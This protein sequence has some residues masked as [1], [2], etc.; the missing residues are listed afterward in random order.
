VSKIDVKW[1][2]ICWSKKDPAVLTRIGVPAATRNIS[3]RQLS[4]GKIAM[5]DERTSNYTSRCVFTTGSAK[6]GFSGATPQ[7]NPLDQS[8]SWSEG[9][10]YGHTFV[11]EATSDAVFPIAKPAIG[12]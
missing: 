3:L 1:C 6:S 5:F 12:Q 9:Q 7:A 10:W 11:I 2:L 4:A 8:L